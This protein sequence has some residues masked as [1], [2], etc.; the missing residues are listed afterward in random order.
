MLPVVN[1]I[2]K[3]ETCRLRDTAAGAI[4]GCRKVVNEMIPVSVKY[5]YLV[6]LY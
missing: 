5:Q 4:T 6:F 2:G 3:L 1:V